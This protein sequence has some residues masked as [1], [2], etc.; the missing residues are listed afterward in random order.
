MQAVIKVSHRQANRKGCIY[1]YKND[2]VVYMPILVL[3]QSI[4]VTQMEVIMMKTKTV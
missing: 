1:E 4:L 2:I 3:M